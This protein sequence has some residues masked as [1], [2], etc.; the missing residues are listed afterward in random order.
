[1]NSQALAPSRK[2]G[3]LAG[4]YLLGADLRELQWENKLSTCLR[5]AYHLVY[6]RNLEGG[7]QIIIDY[8]RGDED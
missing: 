7:L 5:H 1:M 6:Q 8:D 2:E 3:K 4:H